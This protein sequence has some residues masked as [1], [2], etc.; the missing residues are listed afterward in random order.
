MKRQTAETRNNRMEDLVF[1]SRIL[2]DRC[3][4]K[5]P[6]GSNGLGWLTGMMSADGKWDWHGFDARAREVD[7][8]PDC[9]QS[10]EEANRAEHQV[11][12]YIHFSLFRRSSLLR[13]IN[14]R[15][16]SDRKAFLVDCGNVSKLLKTYRRRRIQKFYKSYYGGKSMG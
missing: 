11:S 12:Q 2:C 15:F 4:R 9:F 13:D 6:E 8:C 3:G 7:I 1:Q 16:L 14:S 5:R 10:E